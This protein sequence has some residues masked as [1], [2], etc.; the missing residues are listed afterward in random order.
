M[1]QEILQELRKKIERMDEEL[2][3]LLNERAAISVEV[4]KV[5]RDAGRE[6][7]DPARE[8]MVYRHLEKLN[9]GTLPEAALRGIFREILSASRFLQTPTTVAFLGPEASFC[10]QAALAHFGGGIAA[11]PTVTIPEVFD[12][13]ERGKEQWG[14]VPVENSAEGSVKTTLDRLISTPL[15][16]RAEVYLR[17]RH[18]LLA[19]SNDQDVIRKVYSH[20]QAL[21]QCQAWL[22]T[23]LPGIPLM[24]VESTAGAARRVREDKRGAAIASLLCA[25][26]YGLNILAEGIEDSSA[27]TT[28]F[29]VIGPK[30][31]KTGGGSTGRDKTSLLF[32]T[33]HAPG[34]LQRALTPF[35]DAELNLLRIESFPM[36]DRMWEYLFFVD[37]AGH[38]AE[39]KAQKCLEELRH[40]TAFLKVLG[41]YPRGEELP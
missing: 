9:E 36:R 41:S 19:S 40:R 12:E 30:V 31:G 24:E 4:G 2:V 18:C 11:I 15:T 29:L 22:R 20:P 32:G 5:K 38:E 21:A 13:V 1:S 7:Y 39:E 37:F 28:R 23:H 14:I 26:T 25:E 33:P 16:I 10:H 27:N 34:A 35:A 8:A 6:V 3:R 17:I